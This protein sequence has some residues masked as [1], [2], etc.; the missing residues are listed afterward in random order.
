MQKNV[1][2]RNVIA[3]ALRG[4]AL[5]PVSIFYLPEPYGWSREGV[6]G[7]ASVVMRFGDRSV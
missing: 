5:L 1:Q 4:V 2:K 3:D 6:T 7:F